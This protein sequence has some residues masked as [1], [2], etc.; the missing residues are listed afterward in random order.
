[1]VGD[2]GLGLKDG[3]KGLKR[4]RNNHKANDMMRKGEGNDKK[5]NGGVGW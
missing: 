1:M 2:G 4:L 5:C 3:W